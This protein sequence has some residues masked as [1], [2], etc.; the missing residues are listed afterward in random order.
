MTSGR[1]RATTC[2]RILAAA[3]LL[4]V[5]GGCA[6]NRGPGVAITPRSAWATADP[7]AERL[8]P[9]QPRRLTIHHAGVRDEGD[10]PGAEKM[11]RLYTFSV[12]EKSWGD[13]DTASGHARP[14][15]WAMR[16]Y[17]LLF[18]SFSGSS[19]QE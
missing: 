13:V 16:P 11:R 19:F 15:S 14:T 3:V 10:V 8:R 7:L 9:Q 2:P 5:A 1:R 17:S 18:S 4:A 12:K 6:G